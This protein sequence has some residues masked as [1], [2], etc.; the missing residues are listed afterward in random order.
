MSITYYSHLVLCVK[1]PG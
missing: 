1:Q